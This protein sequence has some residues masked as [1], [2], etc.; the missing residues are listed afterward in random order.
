MTTLKVL[1][2]EEA[3]EESQVLLDQLQKN[4][5]MIPNFHAVLAASPQALKAYMTLHQL[6][7]ETD[8]TAEEMTV[9][10]QTI[11]NEHEC[12]Y[13]FPAHAA[14]A[15]GMGV[16]QSVSDAIK[17]NT[18]LPTEKLEALR[19]FALQ[20]VRN[21]GNVDPS[22]VA[23]FKQAGFTDRSI[24]DVLLVLSQK[25]MSNYLNHMAHTPLDDAFAAF[26]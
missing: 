23:A 10:W 26:A 17:N 12:H 24:A 8:F 7:T 3:P 25:T 14:V 1:N 9:A 13:C 6:V 20:L 15:A 5:G 2:K 4:I 21:R 19:T 11:N 18:P 22:D 16:D